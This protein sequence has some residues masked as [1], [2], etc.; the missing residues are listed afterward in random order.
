M[1]SDLLWRFA[2]RCYAQPGVEQACLRLQAEGANVCLLLCGAWLESRQVPVDAD[3][4]HALNECC[5]HW[6]SEVIEPLRALR[7]RWRSAARTDAD[8]DT[9]REGIKSL[10]LSAERVLLERLEIL[11]RPWTSQS[12]AADWLEALWPS[13]D[14]DPLQSLAIIRAGAQQAQ[15]AGEV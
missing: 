10:E 1:A 14:P 8:L 15:L 2:L 9:L 7:Q 13:A 3:R 5:G 4:L 6:Q 11:T 12:P